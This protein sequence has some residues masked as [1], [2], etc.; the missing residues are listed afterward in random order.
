MTGIVDYYVL[1][2][3]WVFPGWFD[4]HMFGLEL[5]QRRQ[6]HEAEQ[7]IQVLNVNGPRESSAP[8]INASSQARLVQ[9]APT[10]LDKLSLKAQSQRLSAKGQDKKNSPSRGCFNMNVAD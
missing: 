9:G 2:V 5:F 3:M 10:G 6:K 8:G 4:R 1:K 7:D